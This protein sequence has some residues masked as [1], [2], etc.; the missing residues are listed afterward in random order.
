MAFWW[1]LLWQDD[2]FKFKVSQRYSELR[3]NILSEDHIYNIIDSTVIYLGDAVN[4]NFS[5]WPLLGNYIWP[6]Y[7][8]FETYEEEINYL[9]NQLNM[10]T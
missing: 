6:N 9:K 7:Y 5:R 8:I 1:E 4:R 3:T 10:N 2:N